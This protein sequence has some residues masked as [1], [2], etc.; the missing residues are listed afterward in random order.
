MTWADWTEEAAVEF[1]RQK[2]RLTRLGTVIEDFDIAIG[3]VALA[4][5]GRLATLN[6]KHMRRLEGLVVEDWSKA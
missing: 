2:A 4:V 3:S 6:A 5:G 1:G